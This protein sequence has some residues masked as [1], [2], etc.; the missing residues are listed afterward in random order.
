MDKIQ[1]NKLEI[2]KQLEY[3]NLNL[4]QGQTLRA[5]AENIGISKSTVRERL[6]KIGYQYN[7]TNKLYEKVNSEGIQIDREEVKTQ[8]IKPKEVK[9]H[10]RGV[11]KKVIAEPV[12]ELVKLSVNNTV[13]KIPNKKV[14]KIDTHSFTITLKKPLVDKI[15]KLVNKK[16]YK[17]RMELIAVILQMVLDNEE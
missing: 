8:Q 16:G 4:K 17:T 1:F 14:I 9:N 12:K 7:A 5:I 11:T 15:D 2:L 10:I 13:F 3:V 6:S